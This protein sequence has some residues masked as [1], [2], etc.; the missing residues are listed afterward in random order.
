MSSV[1]EPEQNFMTLST[2][3]CGLTLE[4]RLEKVMKLLAVL[5]EI[6]ALGAFEV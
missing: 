2:N 1:L 3:R 5:F 4:V 6:L